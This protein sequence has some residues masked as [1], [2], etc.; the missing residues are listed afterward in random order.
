MMLSCPGGKRAPLYQFPFVYGD[1]AALARIQSLEE[2]V[3][4]EFGPMREID[5]DFN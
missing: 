3:A 1:L 4:R 2:V 5:P